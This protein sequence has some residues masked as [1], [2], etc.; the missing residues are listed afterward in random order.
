MQHFCVTT[1][2]N[3]NVQMFARIHVLRWRY[4]ELMYPGCDAMM[5][6]RWK[7]VVAWRNRRF[8]GRALFHDFF[9]DLAWDR[10][11]FRRAGRC[12]FEYRAKRFGLSSNLCVILRMRQLDML[13][14]AGDIEKHLDTEFALISV[15]VFLTLFI[16]PYTSSL[17]TSWCC[18]RFD[19][20]AKLRLQYLH[21]NGFSPV[22]TRLCLSRLEFC[23]NAL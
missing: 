2:I 13:F 5:N 12:F 19:P 10:E 23:K 9:H 3:M 8:G 22:W 18:L 21:R 4:R 1:R 17:W 7:I 16:V 6:L 11:G 20:E 14:Q 15:P